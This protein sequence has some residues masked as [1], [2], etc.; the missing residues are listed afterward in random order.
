MS[1]P[2]LA[3]QA[4]PAQ[5]PEK[6]AAADPVKKPATKTE[7]QK[8]IPPAQ[9]VQLQTKPQGGMHNDLICTSA[10]GM[11]ESNRA[12]LLLHGWG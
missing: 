5:E 1:Q 9:D 2:L 10:S 7:S 6:K 12:V 4:P 11:R 3:Q 8:R